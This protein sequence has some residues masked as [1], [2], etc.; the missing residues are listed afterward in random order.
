MVNHDHPE[1]IGELLDNLPPGETVHIDGF[2]IRRWPEAD[3]PPPSAAAN[4]ATRRGNKVHPRNAQNRAD[5][6]PGTVRPY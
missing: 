3:T 5:Y 4:R 2:K 1:T 6:R